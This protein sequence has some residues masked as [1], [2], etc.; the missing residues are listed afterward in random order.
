[1]KEFKKH[2]KYLIHDPKETCVVG[3]QVSIRNCLPVSKRKRF[4]LVDILVGAR[5][6]AE[7][8]E[9]GVAAKSVA[10]EA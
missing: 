6:R 2:T 1:M 3:D 5:E 4:E 9:G 8:M 10:E 7:N